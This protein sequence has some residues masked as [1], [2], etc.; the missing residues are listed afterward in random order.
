M[1]HVREIH[2]GGEWVLPLSTRAEIYAKLFEA[3]LK[4]HLERWGLFLET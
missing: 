3:M 4:D 2:E 1:Y